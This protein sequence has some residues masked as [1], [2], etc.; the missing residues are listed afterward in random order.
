M[1]GPL[2]NC[3]LKGRMKCEM[4]GTSGRMGDLRGHYISTSLESVKR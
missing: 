4:N 3:F 2:R 1:Y